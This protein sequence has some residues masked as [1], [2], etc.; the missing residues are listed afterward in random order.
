MPIVEDLSGN[1]PGTHTHLKE[2]G[3]EKVD[4]VTLVDGNGNTI[5]T[6]VTSAGT[7]AL[8]IH[9]A[10]VHSSVV[11]RQ[12]HKHEAVT[13]TIATA[14]T[15]SGTVN[16]VVLADSTGFNVNDFVHINTTN[17][18]NTHPKILAVDAG[19]DTITLDRYLDH[20]HNV[21][22]AVTK[23]TTNMNVLGSLAS[24]VTFNIEP[25]TG[26]VWHITRLIFEMTHGTAGDLT[27]FGGINALTNGCI[28]RARNNGQ[29]NTLTNWKDNGDIKSDMFDVE[30]NER[31]PSSLYGTSG[32]GSF[33]KTGS[34]VSLDGTTN[35]RIELIIQD[36][37][38][39]L[40]TFTMKM[41][42]HVEGV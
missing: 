32:R 21:G 27:K 24:P 26:T 4:E 35:D 20:I 38:T 19:T 23:V 40:T 5:S 33:T 36:S 25:P 29:Y 7:V 6:A 12:M 15:S 11:N 16:E 8:D 10:H 17:D 34:V 14:I 1:N 37:L 39:T 22:D 2:R 9:D 42:G 41:Q 18:E 13:T 31:V 28:L 30:F 3:S